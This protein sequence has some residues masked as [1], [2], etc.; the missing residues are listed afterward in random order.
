MANQKY[1]IELTALD[2]T[3]KAFSAVKTNLSKVKSNTMAATS[4]I[5]KS[6]IAFGLF[7]VAVGAV[8]KSSLEYADAI[9]KTATRTN[10]S[11][12]LIQALQIAFIESG[13]SAE[14][15]EKALTKFAR[16]VGDAQKGLKTYSDIFRDLGVEIEDSSGRFRG[17]E[18][19]LLDSIEAISNLTSITEKASINAQL[20]GRSGII[21]M[22][23]F[24]G[25]ADG[26]REFVKR[27]ND[28]GIGLSEQGVR[29]AE[30]LNDSMFILNKQF[31][32]VKDNLI[33][34]F[35]PV[36]QD[37]VNILQKTFHQISIN[38][39]GIEAFSQSISKNAIDAIANFIEGIGFML[40]ETKKI[41]IRFDILSLQSK[42]LIDTFLDFKGFM[43]VASLRDFGNVLGTLTKSIGDA[44]G[45]AIDFTDKIRGLED[46]LSSV[47]NPTTNMVTRLRELRDTV[48][49]N[50]QAYA[51]L[52]QFIE[53]FR[54]ASEA[55][56][57]S[58]TDQ[59]SALEKF[60][61]TLDEQG[62]KLAQENM[63]VKGFK[64]AEDALVDFTQTGELNFKKMIDNFIQELIRLQIRMTFIKPFFEAFETAGGF[65]KGGFRTGFNAVFGT[66]FEGGGFTGMGARAGGIDGRGGFPAIL[67]P[68][69]TVIDHQKGQTGGVVINQSL[70]FATGVQDTV[71]NEVL[72]MLPDI[73]E[74]SKS[75]VLE[76]MQRGGNFR[77]AMR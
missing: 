43:G 32:S 20:F 75:A 72:Q 9:G 49:Q 25:G 76:A 29:N 38:A 41:G 42:N 73:A 22:D 47:E 68:N 66:K 67:H 40:V 57:V 6:T 2:K 3:K 28:L 13:A 35:I 63:L 53:Q 21:L 44:T 45:S 51:T 26:V 31:N 30:R 60:A 18:T 17:I 74:T 50:T 64:D 10:I 65:G 5:T 77:K 71:R 55:A 19:V 16:T 34:G 70:N 14:T 7:A 61:L 52:T 12:E 58:Y 56:S 48:G 36:F 11:V 1:K 59:Q 54:Q 69:E 33:L 39:G 4:A 15:A 8:V 46:R 23:A 62:L 24:K 37:V 27:M